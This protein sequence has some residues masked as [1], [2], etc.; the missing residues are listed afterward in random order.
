M[1]LVKI[2]F[3][4]EEHEALLKVKGE[5]TWRQFVLDNAGVKSVGQRPK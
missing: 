5:T 3:E 1:K 2:T 4:D